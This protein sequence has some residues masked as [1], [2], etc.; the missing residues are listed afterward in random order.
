VNGTTAIIGAPG[1]NEAFI[2]TLTSG[3]WAQAATLTPSIPANEFG[4]SVGI[5]GTTAIVGA[6]SL[7]GGGSSTGYVFSAFASGHET[8][9]LQATGQTNGD[10]FG[11]SAALGGSTA[12]FGAPG[13]STIP[14]AAYVFSSQATIAAT[15]AL[16]PWTPALLLLLGLAG[17]ATLAARRRQV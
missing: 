8:Q 11:N 5:F 2:Y 7:L 13:S 16:G 15:P 1:V 9:I 17:Y 12:V 3:T 6:G 10:M 4:D 14:G